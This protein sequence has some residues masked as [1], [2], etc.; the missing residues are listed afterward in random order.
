MR[1]CTLLQRRT[2]LLAAIAAAATSS[3]EAARLAAMSSFVEDNVPMR[4]LLLP[5]LTEAQGKGREEQERVAASAMEIYLR[6][7]YRTFLVN[8]FTR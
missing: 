7:T 4:D 1:H 3:N 5:L 6:Q 8:S 2:A